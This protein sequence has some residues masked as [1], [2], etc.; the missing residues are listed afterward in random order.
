MKTLLT[1]VSSAA[2]LLTAVIASGCDFDVPVVFSIAFVSSLAGLFGADY[3]RA[4]HHRSLTVTPSRL[5]ARR[6]RTS[7][8]FASV[9][10]FETTCA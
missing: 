10:V 8:G 4:A 6:A 1:F 3:G 2:I 9:I 5:S 7:A